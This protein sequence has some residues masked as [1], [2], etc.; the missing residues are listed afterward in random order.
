MPDRTTVR[1]D[2]APQPLTAYSQAVAWNGTLF[3]SG[4]VPISLDTAQLE[5][6]SLGDA[7]R[8]C[9][10]YLEEVCR[11]AGAELAQALKITV[12]TT[13]LDRSPELNAAYAEFFAEDPPARVAVEVAGLPL[14][15]EVE[16]EAVVPLL[17]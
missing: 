13:A 5:E 16:I 12:Y 10:G 6:L 8:R 15:A 4:Q 3:C 1:T 7:T 17:Q 14:G 11:A 9:L 2:R